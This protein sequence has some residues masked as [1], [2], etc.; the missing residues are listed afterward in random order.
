MFIF[1]KDLNICE[2]VKQGIDVQYFLGGTTYSLQEMTVDSE[3]IYVDYTKYGTEVTGKSYKHAKIRVFNWA[4]EEVV[5]KGVTIE[6]NTNFSSSYSETNIQNVIALNGAL[7]VAA[8]QSNSGLHVTKVTYGDYKSDTQ[9]L[10]LMEKYEY[11]KAKGLSLSLNSGLNF[12]LVK[13]STHAVNDKTNYAGEG[14][15]GPKKFSKFFV[16]KGMTTDGEYIYL[17]LNANTGSTANGGYDVGIIAKYT[18]DG[19][20]VKATPNNYWW[21]SGVRLSYYNGNIIV[22]RTTGGSSTDYGNTKKLSGNI[23]QFDADTLELI[24]DEYDPQL[25]VPTGG[26]L[27]EISSSPN[28][29]RVAAVYN[30]TEDSKTVRRLYTFDVASDGTMTPVE[31]TQGLNVTSAY[32]GTTACSL[33]GMY[34]SNECLYFVYTTGA[35]CAIKVVDYQGNIIMDDK[36]VSVPGEGTGKDKNYQGIIELKGR[37]YYSITSW[38]GY[39]GTGVYAIN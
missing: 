1:D 14:V 18:V 29:R 17:G 30:Y 2:G 3:Y 19:K 37:V 28:G 24:T 25:D 36:V 5:A 10:D 9:V 22:T 33:M 8:Y 4:G 35:G 12:K 38:S 13:D 7:Y 6:G 31:G 32:N 34:G 15:T 23:L 16:N 26:T 11:T 20:F 39:T 21:G 27:D